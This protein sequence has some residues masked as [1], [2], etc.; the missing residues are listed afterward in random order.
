MVPSIRGDLTV[1]GTSR[2]R[3]WIVG[4]VL[5]VAAVNAIALLLGSLAPTP[6]GPTSSSYATGPDGVAAWA[7]LLERSGRRVERAREAP[8]D[9]NLDAEATLVILDP[10][11]LDT[12]QRKAVLDFVTGGGRVVAGGSYATWVEDLVPRVEWA[13]RPVRVATVVAPAAETAGV[14]QV[15]T[16]GPGSFTST[17][18]ALPLVGDGDATVVALARVG[19]GTV[20]LISDPTFLQNAGLARSDNATLALGIAGTTDAPVVFLESVHGYTSATGLGALPE[21]WKWALALAGL[22]ALVTIAARARRNGPPDEERR[23]LPPPRVAYVDS[24]AG[25]LGRTGR[26]DEAFEGLRRQALLWAGVD[27]PER[28]VDRVA[29][30]FD[31]TEGERRVLATGVRTETDGV[32]AAKALA[33]MRRRFGGDR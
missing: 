30:R 9:L 26:A 31:L 32:L 15:A 23:E 21:N 13:A 6:G 19:E 12:E 7:E 2:R 4:A 10:T 16:G 20:I 25:I 11:G 14:E 17:A 3:R 8:V 28:D 18:E 22:A 1:S 24:M 27:E 5:F 33:K 29:A